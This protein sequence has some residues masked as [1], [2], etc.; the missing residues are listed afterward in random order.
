MAA[1]HPI[2]TTSP[3]HAAA[4]VPEV[5]TSSPVT[6]EKRS[7]KSLDKLAECLIELP[8]IVVALAQMFTNAS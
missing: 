2:D 6:K 4:S 3:S 5:D 8:S 7:G 1:K